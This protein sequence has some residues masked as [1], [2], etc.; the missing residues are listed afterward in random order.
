MWKISFR[1][2]LKTLRCSRHYLPLVLTYFRLEFL[3]EVLKSLNS[4]ERACRPIVCLAQ[5]LDHSCTL[6]WWLII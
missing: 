5:R 4:I 2:L 1:Y 3:D 6:D